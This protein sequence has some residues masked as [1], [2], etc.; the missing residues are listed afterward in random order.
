MWIFLFVSLFLFVCLFVCPIALFCN[1]RFAVWT[2]ISFS[3]QLH[4][5]DLQFRAA[6]ISH[7][8]TPLF[9]RAY[10]LG[11]IPKRFDFG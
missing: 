11:M 7:S 2:A 1:Q 10:F 8:A 6:S 3:D 5:D 4:L 9:P